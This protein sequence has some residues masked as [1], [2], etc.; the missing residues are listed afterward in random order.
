[1]AAFAEKMDPPNELRRF[2]SALLGQTVGFS[3]VGMTSPPG[4][5]KRPRRGWITF[6]DIR[7]TSPAPPPDTIAEPPVLTGI[8]DFVG[9]AS[10]I[11]G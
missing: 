7:G 2:G 6:P 4:T 8:V 1:L 5:T 11:P 3:P 9:S 10:I